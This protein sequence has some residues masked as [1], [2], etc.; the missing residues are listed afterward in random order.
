MDLENWKLKWWIIRWTSN[1]P[2]QPGTL[3]LS[4]SLF[5]FWGGG[6]QLS[7]DVSMFPIHFNLNN[8]HLMLLQ[9]SLQLLQ[10]LATAELWT[11]YS[12][13]T[14]QFCSLSRYS[15]HRAASWNICTHIRSIFSAF[16][17]CRFGRFPLLL[18]INQNS[19]IFF[20]QGP[21]CSLAAVSNLVQ[22]VQIFPSAVNLINNWNF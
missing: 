1:S 14:S 16:W 18:S 5:F 22:S 4:L 17:G 11:L 20:S 6:G 21:L 13:P 12:V 8:F 3:S 7:G 2:Y 19:L 15:R 9:I 10:T